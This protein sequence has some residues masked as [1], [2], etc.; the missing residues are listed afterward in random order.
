MLSDITIEK[1]R[2]ND[3]APC[4][5]CGGVT[6]IVRAF[7]FSSAMARAVYFVRWTVGGLHDA[8]VGVSVGG[9]CDADSTPRRLISL[10]LRQMPN[11]PSFMV[12]DGSLAAWDGDA[13]VGEP[14]PANQVLGSPVA[15]EVFAILDAAALQDDRLHGWRLQEPPSVPN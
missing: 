5:C 7:V 10:K 2:Q 6:R 11:G 3:L 13:V 1:G 15:T 14:L 9:W 4:S 12:V 8:D